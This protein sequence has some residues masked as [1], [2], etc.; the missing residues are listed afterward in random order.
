MT[1]L[2]PQP[3]KLYAF[4]SI[5][6]SSG[7]AC[8]PIPIS[9]PFIPIIIAPQNSTLLLL[10][11]KGGFRLF[12]QSSFPFLC[13]FF[14]CRCLFNWKEACSWR[15]SIRDALAFTSYG[16]PHVLRCDEDPTVE[17]LY[18]YLGGN[19]PAYFF[20]SLYILLEDYGCSTFCIFNSQASV[21]GALPHLRKLPLVFLLNF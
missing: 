12:W 10:G 8:S 17:K 16:I 1:R 7:M 2:L 18:R 3:I 4:V 13:H 19:S 21:W 5:Y 20:P 11:K 14:L 9:G 6:L 15:F